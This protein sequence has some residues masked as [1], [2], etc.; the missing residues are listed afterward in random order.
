MN[1]RPVAAV[2]AGGVL[3]ALLCQASAE[4]E[5]GARAPREVS[6]GYASWAVAEDV[7]VRAGKPAVGG[8]GGRSWLPV[9]GGSADPVAGDAAVDL[10]GE[11][12]LSTAG[13]STAGSASAALTLGEL[14]LRLDDGDGTLHARAEVDGRT[15]RLALADVRRGAASPV[16]RSAGATWTGLRVSLTA[17]GAEL[18]SSWTG[19]PYEEG[20][21]LAPLDITVGMPGDTGEPPPVPPGS[22]EPKPET[23]PE[24]EPEQEPESRPQA[25]KAPLA[26]T[27]AHSTVGTG[28]EQ[29]V[30]GAGFE[31]GEVVLV[32]ID[33]DT[34]YDVVADGSGRVSQ[35]FPVYAT[36]AEGVH[37]VELRTVSGDRT[38][39][40]EFAVRRL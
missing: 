10:A 39:G 23:E 28:G 20:G 22:P 17:E 12:E 1:R 3:T 7:S 26:A 4:A 5:G 14:R 34:R 18:F 31:P 32:A 6:G 15:R 8:A 9:T 21:E 19:E 24:Q 33:D 36:A 30:T 11:L 13:P 29:L 16:V 38:T 27:V 40:A 25:G 37:A 35:A 2:L